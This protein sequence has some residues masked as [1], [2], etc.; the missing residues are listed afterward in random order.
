[1]VN[2][3]KFLFFSPEK[4]LL[5]AVSVFVLTT[6]FYFFGASLR[7]VNDLSLFWPL[8][9]VLAAIFVRNPWLNKAVYYFIC[10]AANADI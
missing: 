8:N 5:N 10:Y 7:L 9:A 6:L 4:M 3:P 2:R 1:M